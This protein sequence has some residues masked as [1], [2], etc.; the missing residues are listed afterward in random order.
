M[1]AGRFG[2]PGAGRALPPAGGGGAER[3]VRLLAPGEGGL[4][5]KRLLNLRRIAL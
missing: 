5:W 3:P 4:Q 1:G 2:T